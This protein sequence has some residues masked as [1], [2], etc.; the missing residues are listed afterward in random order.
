[1]NESLTREQ[2]EEVIEGG[3]AQL[4]LNHDAALRTQL[5]EMTASNDTF[6]ECIDSPGGWRETLHSTGVEIVK[7]AGCVRD[8]EQQI[9]E[10]TQRAESA[11]EASK[12]WVQKC[13]DYE[14]EFIGELGRPG[15]YIVAE[16]QLATARKALEAVRTI[17]RHK[18]TDALDPFGYLIRIAEEV[19]HALR[20][21]DR[22]SANPSLTVEIEVPV[23]QDY[24][25]ALWTETREAVMEAKRKYTK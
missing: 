16:H 11:E 15:K 13:I 2:V 8:M 14:E 23:T 4:F 22:A 9:A 19:E 5:A 24:M 1:M 3:D 20:E 25:N 6:L 18:G 7:L 10:M 12:A 21:M 17:A